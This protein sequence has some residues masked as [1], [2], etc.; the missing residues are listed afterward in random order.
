MWSLFTSLTVILISDF[1]CDLQDVFWFSRG[2]NRQFEFET[3]ALKVHAVV[4]QS[5]F[6]FKTN[7]NS[8]FWMEKLKLSLHASWQLYLELMKQYIDDV[9][10]K[11]LIFF[12]FLLIKIQSALVIRGLF[13]CE[14]AYSYLKNDLKWPF[15]SQK[16]T[17]YLRI[18]DSRSKMTERIY[19]E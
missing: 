18:Q 3:S 6:P 19:R 16:W 4:T 7:Y 9:I 17:F 10:A 1:K 8:V 12:I 5:I 13:I 2:P 14:F 15:F 11:P